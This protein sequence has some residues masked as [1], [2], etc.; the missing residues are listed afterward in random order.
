MVFLDDIFRLKSRLVF[1][2]CEAVI[3]SVV[4]SSTVE[5]IDMISVTIITLN[6]IY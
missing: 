5:L 1:Y 4:I 2:Q 6:C 3:I